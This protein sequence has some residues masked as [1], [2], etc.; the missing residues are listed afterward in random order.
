[1]HVRQ[2]ERAA[3]LSGGIY[4]GRAEGRHDDSRRPLRRG[5]SFLLRWRRL[6]RA[7]RVPVSGRKRVA[8][9]IAA[10]SMWC[11]TG[12]T[13]DCVE[14]NGQAAVLILRDDVPIGLTIDASAQG[15][16]EIKW[17]LRPSKLAAIPRSGHRVDMHCPPG[18]AVR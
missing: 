5:C 4:R 1:P 16:N 10:I 9:F 6:V 2:F 15:I 14:T 17:F 7:A 8:T 18:P 3:T 13:L 12:V 11:W